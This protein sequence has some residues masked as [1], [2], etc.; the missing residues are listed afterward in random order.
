MFRIATRAALPLRA[1]VRQQARAAST[2]PK[3][4][5]GFVSRLLFLSLDLSLIV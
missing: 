3:A 4:D 2:A 1:A 5:A